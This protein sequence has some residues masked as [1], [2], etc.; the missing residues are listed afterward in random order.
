VEVNTT[1]I[2]HQWRGVIPPHPA[3]DLFPPL[4]LDELCGLAADIEKNGLLAAIVLTA[5]GTQVIDGCNRLDALELAGQRIFNA[6]DTLAVQHCRLGPGEDPYERVVSLNIHRRHLKVEQ[7][8]ELI[9]KLLKANPE[10]SDRQ[11]ARLTAVSD[12]TVGAVR[13]R[14][15]GNADIPHKP[16]RVEADG[17]KARGRKPTATVPVAAE[18]AVAADPRHRVGRGLAEVAV[19]R[20]PLLLRPNLS[21]REVA[22]RVFEWLEPPTRVEFA[23]LTARL[24]QLSPKDVARLSPKDFHRFYPKICSGA[25]E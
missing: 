16:D 20:K 19:S 1:D 21:T 25:V 24:A 22:Q 15:E 3:A 12:K 14:L 7:K 18:P 4:S 8:R 5:D 9:A 10:R 2:S 23:Q 11:V 13:Q 6:D 17:R